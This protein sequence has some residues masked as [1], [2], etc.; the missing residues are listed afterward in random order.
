MTDRDSSGSRTTSVPTAALQ[1]FTESIARIETTVTTIKD[2]T[3]PP[4]ASAAQEARDGVLRLQE[5]Q[6][7]NKARLARLEERPEPS[8]EPCEMVLAHDGALTAQERELAGLSKWR[9]WVMGV[10]VT[11]GLFGAGLAGRA[12]LAQGEASSDRAGQRRDIDRH[13]DVLKSVQTEARS[14]R[15]AILREVRAVPTKV[16]KSIP[17]PDLDDALDEH[18]LT[19][20]ERRLVEEILRRAEKRNGHVAKGRGR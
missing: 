5:Q 17:E 13:E 1:D 7:V 2:E 20:R 10:A 11:L 9:W 6:K 15:D 14:N 12:L 4:V 8:H 19:D 18:E 16:Q 3:I